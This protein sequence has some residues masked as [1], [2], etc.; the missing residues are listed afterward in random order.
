MDLKSL[1]VAIVTFLGGPI[2]I[3]DIRKVKHLYSK[4]KNNNKATATPNDSPA[5][6]IATFYSASQCLKILDAKKNKNVIT[7]A[8]VCKESTSLK[9]IYINPLMDS[10]T[11][12]LLKK[13]K[14]WTKTN[15]YKFAWY[16]NGK[17]L[18]KQDDNTLPIRILSQKQLGKLSTGNIGLSTE[19]P[20]A[21]NP[22]FSTINQGQAAGSNQQ[23]HQS[24]AQQLPK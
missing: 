12:Q 8:N 6:I 4:Q 1:V 2:H 10:S 20:C 13:C 9:K 23:S 3:S 11:Y 24:I 22:N 14:T 17:I 7:N 18:M 19:L 16:S 21:L 5:P 15:G